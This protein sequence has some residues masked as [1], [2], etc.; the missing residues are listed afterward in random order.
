MP[1]PLRERCGQAAE[2]C[3]VPDFDAS[4]YSVRQSSAG[5]HR[6]VRVM[7][8]WREGGCDDGMMIGTLN[9]GSLHKSL[10][11]WYAAPGDLVECPVDGYV[12][13][14]VRDDLLIEVQTGGFG[15][16]R[17]KLEDLTQRHMVRVVAPIAHTRTIIRVADDGER[18]SSRRS[19]KHGRY[20]DIFTRLVSIPT[21]IEHE[22]FEL[23][24]LLTVEDEV[25]VYRPGQA[26]RRKGWVVLGRALVDVVESKRIRTLTDL[27]RLLPAGL[28]APFST[29]DLAGS[30]DISRRVAQHMVYCLRALGMVEIAGKQGNTLLYH[31]SG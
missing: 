24:I 13:D 23:D 20:E 21:M 31:R 22:G 7:H 16:L 19:P 10:K 3:L 18:L 17:T 1:P 14:L 4:R 15:P 5:R 28:P 25:R 9:E 26:W 11:T 30:A 29:A 8:R 6:S 12:I 27:A 2:S